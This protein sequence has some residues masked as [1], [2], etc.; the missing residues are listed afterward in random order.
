MNGNDFPEISNVI[1]KIIGNDNL[2]LKRG[3]GGG[4]G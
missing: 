4:D 3:G 1:V 2:I